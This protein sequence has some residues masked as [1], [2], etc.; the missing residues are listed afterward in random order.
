[1]C[2]TIF[3]LGGANGVD[4][5]FNSSKIYEYAD[6]AGLDPVAL[7][8]FRVMFVCSM[9]LSHSVRGKSGSTVARLALN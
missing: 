6:N 7:S 3:V 8:M 1:M 2:V 5:R 9:S 4:A